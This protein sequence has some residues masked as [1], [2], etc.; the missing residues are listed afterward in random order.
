M[1]AAA[2]PLQVVFRHVAAEHLVALAE[3]C[4]GQTVRE[5]GPG[6]ADAF[7]HAIATELVKDEEGC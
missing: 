7:E 5:T 2:W 4:E 3:F 1:A 6:D